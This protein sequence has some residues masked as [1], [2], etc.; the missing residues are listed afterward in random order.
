M[1][2]KH[3]NAWPSL[4]H[5][6]FSLIEKF[7]RFLPVG[8]YY[9]TLIRPRLSWHIAEPIIRRIAG[10]GKVEL[11]SKPEGAYEHRYRHTDVAIV[12]GGPAGLSAAAEASR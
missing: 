6:F 7:S 5:D 11:H 10:L 8:F 4:D 2:I 12:G 3:Q 1:K 9:K